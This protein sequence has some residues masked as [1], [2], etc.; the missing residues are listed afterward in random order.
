M[1]GH[2]F[3]EEKAV[4]QYR[5][6]L[7]L[8]QEHDVVFLLTDNRE[9]RWL[10]TVMAAALHKTTLC[11][12]LGFE[13]FL[14]MRHGDPAQEEAGPNHRLGCYFC[15]DIVAPANVCCCC[16]RVPLFGT[17]LCV[18]VTRNVYVRA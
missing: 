2:V 8:M 1:P 11:C 4:Q 9:S 13:S 16:F 14:C 7:G 15:S 10:P 3:S 12:G 6:L 18:C 17:A 5:E